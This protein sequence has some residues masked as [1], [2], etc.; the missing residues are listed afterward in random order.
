[1]K[2]KLTLILSIFLLIFGLI[3]CEKESTQIQ[4][5]DQ[6]EVVNLK[7]KALGTGTIGYWKNHPEAWPINEI[8]I[9]GI[10]YSKEAAIEVMKT[11]KGKNPTKGDKTYDMFAQMVATRLNLFANNPWDCIFDTWW[12][13][14]FWMTNN[15]LGS[16]VGAS[17]DAW[18]EPLELIGLMHQKQLV[19]CIQCLM[20][21]IT[22]SY[23]QYT[24]M[25]CRKHV[26]FLIIRDQVLIPFFLEEIQ[27]VNN[28][29]Y[30]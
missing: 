1:M 12:K 16:G 30:T 19:N 10:L 29:L 6:D 24:V 3:S 20:L 8:E 22:V 26:S 14:N 11:I 4:P 15:P 23:V 5:A 17:S 25:I 27:L 7:N 18:Q 28:N 13:A 2:T 21:T 9:G